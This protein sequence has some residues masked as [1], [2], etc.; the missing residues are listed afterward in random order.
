MSKVRLAPEVLATTTPPS[1]RLLLNPAITGFVAIVAITIGAS[2]PHSAFALKSPGAW[3]FGIPGPTGQPTHGSIVAVLS[4]Y[5][6]MLLLLKSW[7]TLAQTVRRHPGFKLAHLAG[8][9][10]LWVLPLLFIPP[11][12]SRDVYSYAA[13][14]EMVSRGISPYHF[15]PDT[16]GSNPYVNSV[17]PLWGNSPA[18][19]GPLFLGLAGLLATVTAHKVL[20]TVVG[21]RLLALFGVGLVAYFLPK[22]ARHL[23]R[24]PAEAFVLAVLNPVTLLHLIAGAHNDAL[25][26]GLMVA[27]LTVAKRG[28]PVAGIVLCTLA[29]AVKAPAAL[30][31]VYIGWEWMGEDIPWR[32]R[33]RPVATSLLIATGV[34]AFLSRVSGLGW[35]WISALSTPGTVRNLISPFTAL[36]VFVGNLVHGLGL[37]ISPA[38]LLALSRAGGLALAVVVCVALLWNSHKLGSIRALAASLLVIVVFSPVIWSWYLAWGIILLVPVA[39]GRLYLLVIGLSFAACYVG[40]PTSQFMLDKLAQVLQGFLIAGALIMVLVPSF[41]DVRWLKVVIPRRALASAATDDS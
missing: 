26:V 13:Q 10:A 15:G 21:L 12:F 33:V 41:P 8:V 37:G 24:D 29:A 6:G 39:T 11:L 7:W 22:L 36:G 14:G 40:L 32:E 27:G 2:Q 20:A 25:M 18:P 34:M 4:V 17:D 23:G 28:R 3:F 16:L 19:Y 9:F 5:G 35:G 1:S 38:A 31:V 30:A